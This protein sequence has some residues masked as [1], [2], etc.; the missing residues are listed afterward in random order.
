MKTKTSE[1]ICIYFIY[2]A[3]T[4]FSKNISQKLTYILNKYGT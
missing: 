1:M 3:K 4:S 2:E